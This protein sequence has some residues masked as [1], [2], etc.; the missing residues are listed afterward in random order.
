[1]AANVRPLKHE[2]V[3]RPSYDAK[4]AQTCDEA[5]LKRHRHPS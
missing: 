4:F 5:V 2:H 3:F 1:M